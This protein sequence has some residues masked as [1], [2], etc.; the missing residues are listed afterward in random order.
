MY[1][2]PYLYYGGE[3]R[4]AKSHKRAQGAILCAAKQFRIC[5][6]TLTDII[7]KDTRLYGNDGQTSY[8]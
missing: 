4:G 6:R 1:A 2:A 7:I 3:Q 8:R 5:G